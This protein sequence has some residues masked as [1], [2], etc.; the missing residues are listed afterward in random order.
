MLASSDASGMLDHGGA[1]L[2]GVAVL[3]LFH[4]VVSALLQRDAIQ[5]AMR[6]HHQE[7]A[8]APPGRLQ[9]A[10][11]KVLKYASGLDARLKLAGGIGVGTAVI[12]AAPAVVQAYV[13]T[14]STIGAAFGVTLRWALI[15]GLVHT[16]RKV[17]RARVAPR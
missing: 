15:A 12:G 5:R 3:W 1:L 8:T 13:G 11:Q 10:T 6:Q 16:L 7:P 2:I 9:V 4:R 14:E 17:V